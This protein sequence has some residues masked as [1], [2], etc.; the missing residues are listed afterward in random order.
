MMDI[1]T[2]LFYP[3]P[4]HLTYGSMQA[5][6][7]FAVCGGLLLVALLIRLDRKSVV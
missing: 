2:Y 1:L 5:L 4:G 3:N 7:A 6:I